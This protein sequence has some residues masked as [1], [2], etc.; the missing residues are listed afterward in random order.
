[1][2]PVFDFCLRE[3][4]VIF[5][6][7]TANSRYTAGKEDV[8]RLAHNNPPNTATY[9]WCPVNPVLNSSICTLADCEIGTGRI[10]AS[11]RRRCL[12]SS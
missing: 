10:M 6:A 1:M 2:S 8:A 5:L 7:S 4:S 9:E 11:S 12:T 3:I